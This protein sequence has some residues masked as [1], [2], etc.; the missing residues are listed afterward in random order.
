MQSK[1]WIAGCAGKRLSA[2]EKAFFADERPFG[3]IL[4]GRNIG[5]A[6]ELRDLI[7]ELKEIGG[8]ATTPVLVDQEGGRVQRLRPPLAPSYPPAAVL[9]AL[10]AAE[11]EAAERAAWLT[12]RLF[13][14]DLAAYG[15]NFDCL[16]CLDLH[17]GGATKAIGDRAYAAAP[18]VVARLGGAAARGLA[19]GGLTPVMKHLPGHGRATMDSHLHLP[20]VEATRAELSASDIQPFRALN[21]LPAAMTAHILFKDID[22]T[23]PTTLSAIVIED[24]IREEIGFDG[25]LMTDDMS[26]KALE[27]DMG[28]LSRRAIAAGC[29]LALHCNGDMAEMRKVAG[30]VPELDGKAALRA[31]AAE[32]YG[33]ARLEPADEAAL[34]EDY[35]RLTSLVA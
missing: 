24:V 9:G 6:G 1:A 17:V 16:P 8:R 29:D 25:L 21:D 19:A 14:F 13:A 15:F 12:G 35:A 23:A 34:R 5:E 18:D 4:F 26:M 33:P 28:E 2:D 27:G 10:H 31:E 32:V 11:P 20:R 7:A 30:A 3:F 22:A